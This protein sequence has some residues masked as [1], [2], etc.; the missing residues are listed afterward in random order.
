MC[1]ITIS[2]MNRV[3]QEIEKVIR[4]EPDYV[5]VDEMLDI[6]HIAGAGKIGASIPHYSIDRIAFASADS[7]NRWDSPGGISADICRLHCA[8]KLGECPAQTSEQCRLGCNQ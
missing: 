2:Q 8:S 4:H 5:S 7:R 6:A 1:D 3:F